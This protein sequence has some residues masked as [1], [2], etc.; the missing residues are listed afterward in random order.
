MQLVFPPYPLQTAEMDG[1]RLI[2]DVVR[3]KWVALQPEEWVRQHL[4]H[5]LVQDQGIAPGRIGVEKEIRYHRLRRR[6]DVVVFGRDGLPWLLCECKAPDVA[7]S[8]AALQQIAR[9]NSVI[10]APRLLVTNGLHLWVFDLDETGTYRLSP[11][12]L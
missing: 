5:Y 1:K 11:G 10:R 4:I 7:L 2:F 8:D 12:G 6:F 3:K 9:Y